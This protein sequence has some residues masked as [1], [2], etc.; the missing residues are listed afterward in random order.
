MDKCIFYYN[1]V[2]E[3][4]S[5]YFLMNYN[6]VKFNVMIKRI[7]MEKLIFRIKVMKYDEKMI[8]F[9]LIMFFLC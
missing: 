5:V 4:Y 2:F 3:F 1:Y 6:W 7:L 8:I 9:F